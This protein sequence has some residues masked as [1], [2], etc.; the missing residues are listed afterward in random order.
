MRAQLETSWV[1]V[2]SAPPLPSL[3][4]NGHDGRAQR[5]RPRWPAVVIVA[6]GLVGALAA[7]GVVRPDQ[8]E[9]QVLTSEGE[10]IVNAAEEL[11]RAEEE[12]RLSIDYLRVQ[13]GVTTRQRW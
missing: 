1:R 3:R 4:S 13:L 5:S 12:V 8:R 9:E 6:A 10:P 11:E 2:T 7:W